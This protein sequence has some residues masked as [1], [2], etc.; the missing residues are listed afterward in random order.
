[1]ETEK[2]TQKKKYYREHAQRFYDKNRDD[3]LAKKK[4]YYQNVLKP[5]REALKQSKNEDNNIL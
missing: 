2:V 1:M 5:K 3:I 4:T